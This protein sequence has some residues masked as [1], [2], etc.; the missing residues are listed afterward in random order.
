M[1]D[2]RWRKF[3]RWEAHINRW[4][5]EATDDLVRQVLVWLT[6]SIPPNVGTNKASLLEKNKTIVF[7]R[8]PTGRP[9]WPLTVTKRPAVLQVLL[10][11]LCQRLWLPALFRICITWTLSSRSDQETWNVY[12]DILEIKKTCL[13]A[14]H[15][16]T[17][18]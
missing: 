1:I 13:K 2:H 4:P 10:G 17:V 11:V 7:V 12:V 8:S 9:C 14:I 5:T 18:R 16:R 6:T 3:H 15:H